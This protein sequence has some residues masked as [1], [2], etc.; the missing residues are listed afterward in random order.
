MVNMIYIFRA[1]LV[2]KVSA[3][4]KSERKLQERKETIIIQCSAPWRHSRQELCSNYQ[5]WYWY[6][7]DLILILSF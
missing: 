5:P 1:P 7:G 4:E 3:F 2:Y 6:I